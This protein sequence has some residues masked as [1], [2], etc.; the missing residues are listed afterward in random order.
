MADLNAH[1][2]LGNLQCPRG[3]A[4]GQARTGQVV[5]LEFTLE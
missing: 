5:S 1:Q 2:M 4:V 3:E